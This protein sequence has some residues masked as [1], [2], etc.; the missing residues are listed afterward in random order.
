M[1]REFSGLKYV[2]LPEKHISG[3][4]HM[5]AIASGGMS[6][7]WLKNNARECGFG[8]KAES[9]IPISLQLSVFYCLKYIT[10]SLSERAYWPK[11]L[12]RVRT[13]QKWPKAPIE[14]YGADLGVSMKPIGSGKW[15]EY[16]YNLKQSGW[17]IVNID[18][19]ESE[20]VKF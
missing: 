9:E 10:K 13:S 14:P 1:R 7:R 17:L 19:G 3:R 16:Y 5:H 20:G 2:F 15:T 6:T 18:T 12:H 4:L 8:Y 11:S